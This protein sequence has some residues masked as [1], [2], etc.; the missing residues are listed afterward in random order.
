MVKDILL[1]VLNTQWWNYSWFPD[2]S[3]FTG[4]VVFM[5]WWGL[6]LLVALIP[7]AIIIFFIVAI[8]VGILESL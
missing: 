1:N 6:A 5:F 7:L 2:L 3:E 4:M 8:F